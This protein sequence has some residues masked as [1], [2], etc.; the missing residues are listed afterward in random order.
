[1]SAP[2]VQ[3][4][5]SLIALQ[6]LSKLNDLEHMPLQ[7]RHSNKNRKHAAW[8]HWAGRRRVLY[9][10][11][12]G[13]KTSERSSRAGKEAIPNLR[14]TL[15]CHHV[16]DGHD[17]AKRQ[18]QNDRQLQH[19]PVISHCHKDKHDPSKPNEYTHGIDC[20]YSCALVSKYP[21]AEASY[22][23]YNEQ[24]HDKRISAWQS[25]CS[26]RVCRACSH[27]YNLRKQADIRAAVA[28]QDI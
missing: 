16:E 22:S 7:A 18:A 23:C 3:M 19:C 24:L 20:Q 27:M 26:F 11:R 5:A 10:V 2:L 14:E 9:L 25:G 4:S 8:Q 12:A 17:I 28:Y 13:K 6:N 1:M 15:A 21:A